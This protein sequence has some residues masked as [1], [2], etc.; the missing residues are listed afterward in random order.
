M[1]RSVTVRT[2]DGRIRERDV[3]KI[4]FLEKLN[5]RDADVNNTDDEQKHTVVTKERYLLPILS[6]SKLLTKATPTII[7]VDEGLLT[8]WTV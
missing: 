3:R 6:A 7:C 1:V 5:D 2:T 8:L 4:V